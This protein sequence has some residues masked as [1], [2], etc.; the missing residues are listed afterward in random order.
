MSM[1]KTKAGAGRPVL[2]TGATSGIGLELAGLLMREA[3]KH[4]RCTRTS[5][6]TAATELI[7]IGMLD[8]PPVH[9]A[10]MAAAW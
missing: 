2:I 1:T 5:A 4:D 6:L 3:G 8:A 10:V 9:V 7:S